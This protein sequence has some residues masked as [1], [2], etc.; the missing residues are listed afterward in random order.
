MLT[1]TSCVPERK[2]YPRPNLHN[3]FYTH[4]KG[5]TYEVYGVSMRESTG[6]WEVLYRNPSSGLTFH[7]PFSE[8][9]ADVGGKPRFSYIGSTVT[10][11]DALNCK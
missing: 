2:V 1:V 4:Y 3:G 9:F 5:G 8:F 6:E 7:R 11:A 10:T